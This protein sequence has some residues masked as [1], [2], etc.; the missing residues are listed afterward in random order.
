MMATWAADTCRWPLRA[1]ITSIK[2]KRICWSLLVLLVYATKAAFVEAG[3]PWCMRPYHS[4]CWLVG[5]CPAVTRDLSRPADSSGRGQRQHGSSLALAC[6]AQSGAW[7]HDVH[8][9]TH[10]YLPVRLTPRKKI[11][12]KD[13]LMFPS[14]RLLQ[15]APVALITM[16]FI[17]V[18]WQLWRGLPVIKQ[19]LF[20]K[21]I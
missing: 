2:P 16:W 6:G 15:Y 4:A 18:R 9:T 1:K 13:E 3:Q 11:Q 19:V 10:C 21:L 12:S 17:I 14:D 8:R 20:P 5:I 7:Y